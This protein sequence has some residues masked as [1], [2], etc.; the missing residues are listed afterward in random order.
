M[1]VIFDTELIGHGQKQCVS[2]RDGL[3][4][5][6][7]FNKDVRCGGM[8]PTEDRSGGGTDEADAVLILAAVAAKLTRD[9]DRVDSGR[10]YSG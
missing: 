10:R 3:V 7:L 6:E 1:R 8:V 4:L 2:F 5:P 9:R